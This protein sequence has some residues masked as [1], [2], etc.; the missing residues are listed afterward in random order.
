VGLRVAVP[1]RWGADRAGGDVLL[2]GLRSRGIEIRRFLKEPW[3]PEHG[4][5]LVVVGNV[6][7]YPI[8][9]R[10]LE[11]APLSQLPTTIVW[12]FEPLP[13]PR[14][15]GL[16]KPWLDHREIAKVL[17]RD[18][19]VTDP[20]SNL[21]RLRSLARRGL[22]HRLFVSTAERGE[23][24][25]EYGIESE[26]L[27]LG[28][29]PKQGR[30]LGLERDIDTLFLGIV[31][32][33][34]RM[35]LLQLRLAG[36]KV[37]SRGGW[38]DPECWGD[39]RTRLLNRTKIFLVVSRFPGQFTRLRFSLAAANKTLILS[40]P[41][42]NSEEYIPGQHYV[43]APIAEMPRVARYYLEHEEERQRITEAAHKLATE[44]E[45]MDQALDRLAEAIFE[46]ASGDGPPE[47]KQT[48]TTPATTST[49][50]A[51]GREIT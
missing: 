5:V 12:H 16:P 17:L 48:G 6:S 8:L 1:R 14:R 45:T 29:Y 9:R 20:Y 31:T 23:L 35:R 30:D 27:P 43:A 21:R 40:E 10:Q 49:F 36:L 39:N 32:L 24:L 7:W 37:M 50:T 18:E 4:R 22:P 44:V 33:R 41:H 25:R 38:Q 15:S 51:L 28:Y 34:R 42:Y 2:D 13:P 26:P 19:R 3:R 11:T 47:L 46:C